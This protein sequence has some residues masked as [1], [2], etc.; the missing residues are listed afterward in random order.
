[1]QIKD[2]EVFNHVPFFFWVK[3]QEGR[4]LWVNKALVQFAGEDIVCKNDY[5]VPWA[6]RADTLIKVDQE[7][8]STGKAHCL[9]E[10]VNTPE[11]NPVKASVCKFVGELD[12]NKCNFGIAFVIE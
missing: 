7:V 9:H 12:G 8:L 6:D 4:Y 1:M 3:D 5:D 2:L 10:L 11:G